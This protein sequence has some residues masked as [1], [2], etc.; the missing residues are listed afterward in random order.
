MKA[1]LAMKGAVTRKH[2]EAFDRGELKMHLRPLTYRG[3]A[4]DWSTKLNLKQD[5][6]KEEGRIQNED[7]QIPLR[8]I[9]CSACMERNPT[10]EMKLKDGSSF[11]NLKS[12]SGSK[13]TSSR[14]WLCE[15]GC[16]WYKCTVHYRPP[17]SRREL[18]KRVFKRK[19]TERGLDLPLPKF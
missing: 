5:W 19:W 8:S 7:G 9:T 10:R 4:K 18:P 12:R 3:T 13:V 14:K 17:N 2:K 1:I 16:L 15:C 6:T 11:S